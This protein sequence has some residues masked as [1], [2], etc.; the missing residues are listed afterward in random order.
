MLLTVLIRFHPCIAII[1]TAKL[2][3]SFVKVS[4]K[5]AAVCSVVR[6]EKGDVLLVY[7][8]PGCTGFDI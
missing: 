3:L 4:Q 1:I 2:I 6:R 5:S 7:F 8:Q